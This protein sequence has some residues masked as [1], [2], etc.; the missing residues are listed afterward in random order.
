MSA[1]KQKQRARKQPQRR[2]QSESAPR[3]GSKRWLLW[4]A[5]VGI[6][7]LLIYAATPSKPRSEKTGGASVGTAPSNI[8]PASLPAIAAGPRIQ[9]PSLVYDFGK[10]IGDDLVDC[11]FVFTNTGSALLEVSEVTPAC[12]CMK[13]AGFS[14]QA[15][16]GK[17]GTI[18]VQYNS[19]HYTGHFAKSV[20]VTCNDPRRPKVTLEIQGT[21]WRPIE[22]TPPTAMLN[23]SAESPS[24]AA[25]VRIVSNLETPLILSDV[26]SKNPAF[27]VEVQTNQPGKEYQLLVWTA[28]PFPTNSQSGQI[29]LKTSATNQP[30]LTINVWA[31]VQP[32]V[33]L[34]PTQIGLPPLPLTNAFA[35]KIWIENHGTNILKLSEPVVN[36]KGVT[37]QMH[38]DQPGRMFAVTV[39]FPGGF[40][41]GPEEKLELRLNSNHPLFP[42]VK[43]PIAQ[44]PH[45][46]KPAL[47]PHS[48]GH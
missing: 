4:P 12:G 25:T 43:V 19:R 26:A 20:W 10:V 27:A 34:V 8:A 9:F 18:S 11:V 6:T 1:R 28:P 5:L 23:L 32:I 7:A 38:E 44:T 15:E 45:G 33:T 30:A 17:T 48:V 35:G 36:A 46:A 41:A 42:V 3:A 39:G 37:V 14:R 40:E 22:I 13:L 16:P 24:N 29:T 31:N 47:A 21:V 2:F